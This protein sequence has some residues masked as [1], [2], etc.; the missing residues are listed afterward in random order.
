MFGG[1]L[2]GLEDHMFQCSGCNI[3]A[4]WSL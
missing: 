3:S 1:I 4:S 2:P